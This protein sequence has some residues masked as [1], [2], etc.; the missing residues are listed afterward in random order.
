M[1]IFGLFSFLSKKPKIWFTRIIREQSEAANQD[2]VQKVN[3]LIEENEKSKT[4]DLVS[5]RHSIT[6]IYENHK[7]EKHLSEHV[8]ADLF[9]LYEQYVK[10]GGNSYVHSI[11]EEM[12]TWN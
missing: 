11:M 12:K 8:K 2:L 9:S 7:A 1:A 3:T 5:L 4:R 6:G 10:L